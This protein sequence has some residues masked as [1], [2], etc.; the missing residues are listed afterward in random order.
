[1]AKKKSYHWEWW[2]LCEEHLKHCTD[3]TCELALSF[4]KFT[5]NN[6]KR[7]ESGE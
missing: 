3:P 6:K 5:A 7:A 1:M 2:K 4:S